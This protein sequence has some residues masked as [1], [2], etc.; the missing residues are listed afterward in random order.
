MLATIYFKTFVP[1]AAITHVKFRLNKD[2][3]ILMAAC[4]YEHENVSIW[5]F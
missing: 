5:T 3:I 1:P 2:K 4:Q